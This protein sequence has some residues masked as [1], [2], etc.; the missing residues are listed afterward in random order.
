MSIFSVI[1]TLIVFV[2]KLCRIAALALLSIMYTLV[3]CLVDIPGHRRHPL[4]TQA[5]AAAHGI[6]HII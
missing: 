5:A 6:W 2:V 4:R 1:Y 3:A